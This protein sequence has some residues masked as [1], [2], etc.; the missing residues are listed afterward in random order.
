MSQFRLEHIGLT[1]S[2]LEQML[3]F[4]SEMLG[5]TVKARIHPFD[6]NAVPGITGVRDAVVR[7]IAYVEKGDVTFEL[8]EYR[9]PTPDRAGSRPCDPGY[10]HWL[11]VVDDFAEATAAA[12]K[13]GFALASA[14][15]RI[16][17]GPNAGKVGSYLRHDD[18]FSLEII[19]PLGTGPR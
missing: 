4:F 7:E 19:G 8:L 13:Y 18:G 5:F 10:M 15:Y 14:P 2:D 16:E 1:V 17:L 11:I 9:E 3:A 6:P 12:A